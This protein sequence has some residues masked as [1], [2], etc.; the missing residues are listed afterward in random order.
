M[1][2]L[3]Q[4]GSST[5]PRQNSRDSHESSRAALTPV[6][7]DSMFQQR[8]KKP[9]LGSLQDSVSQMKKVRPPHSLSASVSSIAFHFI[10]GLL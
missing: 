5:L 10:L 7:D 3:V 8:D 6:D 9:A 1:Y 2:L 4:K